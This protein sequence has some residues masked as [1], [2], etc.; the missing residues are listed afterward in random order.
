LDSIKS[1]LTGQ[2]A[3]LMGTSNSAVCLKRVQI[4]TT[5]GFL[6]YRSGVRLPVLEFRT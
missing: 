6:V 1:R 4:L 5:I 3:L 2:Q